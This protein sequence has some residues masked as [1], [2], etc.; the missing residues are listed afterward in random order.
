MI[1]VFPFLFKEATSYSVYMKHSIQ[2][3]C[4]FIERGFFLSLGTS[5]LESPYWAKMDCRGWGRQWPSLYSGLSQIYSKKWKVISS[6]YL[7]ID[8]FMVTLS[9]NNY[10]DVYLRAPQNCLSR[11]RHLPVAGYPLAHSPGTSSKGKPADEGK[12][13]FVPS[14]VKASGVWEKCQIYLVSPNLAHTQCKACGVCSIEMWWRKGE[15]ER[16]GEKKG[17]KRE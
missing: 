16:Q 12:E 4:L 13:G 7:D 14:P 8:L 10:L 9:W 15:G 2:E 5:H 1:S 3:R 11:M 17:L 6:F